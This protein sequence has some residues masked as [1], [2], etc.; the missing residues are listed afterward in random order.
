MKII[1]EGPNN[2]GKSTLIKKYFNQIANQYSE[3]LNELKDFEKCKIWSVLTQFAYQHPLFL[4]SI[5][6][7]LRVVKNVYEKRPTASPRDK[8]VGEKK[9]SFI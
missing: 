2:V 1:I 7:S 5:D 8:R 3:L 4:Q 9:G 6:D